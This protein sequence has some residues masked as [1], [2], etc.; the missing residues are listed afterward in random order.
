M[1]NSFEEGELLR[2][3]VV[4][5]TSPS[6]DYYIGGSPNHPDYEDPVQ[7]FYVDGEYSP[8]TTGTIFDYLQKVSLIEENCSIYIYLKLH[9]SQ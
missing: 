9:C 8:N 2:F 4:A 7:I 3:G 1:L 6:I 5:H